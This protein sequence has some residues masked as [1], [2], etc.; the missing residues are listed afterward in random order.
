MFNRQQGNQGI[1]MASS[2]IT[3]I[4]AAKSFQQR[5]RGTFLHSALA[6]L[7][8]LVAATF[9]VPC[10]A[11]GGLSDG[12]NTCLGCHSQ[13]RFSK[14]LGDGNTLSL[15]ISG[16]AFAK[17]VH[18]PI[19]CAGCHAD[20]NL[21]KHP[22]AGLKIKNAR[23]FSIAMIEKCRGCHEDVAK[24]YEGSVH[25]VRLKAGNEQV[26]ICTDCHS[27]HAIRSHTAYDVCVACHEPAMSAHQKWL[28][29]AGLH[30]EV[31]A[32]AAC[33]APTAKRMVDLRLYDGATGKWAVEKDGAP[34]FGKLAH[35]ADPGGN[36]LGAAELRN[37]MAQIN[38]DAK[39]PQ[40]TLRG[41]IEMVSGVEAH[42]LLGKAAANK[43]CATCHRQGAEPFQT[44]TVSVIGADGDPVRFKANRDVLGSVLSVES[45]GEFYAVGGTR[46][47]ILDLLF[48][49]AVLG[50]LSVPVV[51]QLMKLI[52]RRQLALEAAKKAAKGMNPGGIEPGD[53]R[54]HGDAPKQK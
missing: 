53:E 19:G 44:V 41:R 32:C 2:T 35:A 24:Q 15:H 33:H 16:D 10:A 42:H 28:P 49:L 36:G 7:I 17:S 26:P 43:E 48:I 22:Q 12:D 29:N 51:H 50:G 8:A 18:Q 3:S 1:Q 6:A 54:A 20:I 4:L 9:V 31:V 45:L 46:N 39:A 30:L 11:A 13:E 52:V 27:S 37:L 38:H 21:E 34:E 47:M 25:A 23:E 40:K 5:R 14:N